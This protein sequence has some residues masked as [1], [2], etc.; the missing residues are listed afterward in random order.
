M[1]V[2]ELLIERAREYEA[3]SAS[4][5]ERA[6]LEAAARRPDGRAL[7]ELSSSAVGFVSVAITLRELA[8]VLEDAA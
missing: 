4:C 3:R 1:S 8:D 7:A 6:E 5:C 2:R